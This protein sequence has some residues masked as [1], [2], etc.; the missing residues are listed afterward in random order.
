MIVASLF[1]V[2]Q[3]DAN[4]K[5]KIHKKKKLTKT[6]KQKLGVPIAFFKILSQK[7]FVDFLTFVI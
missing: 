5:I 6:F 2:L 7:L 3:S 4:V 1:S